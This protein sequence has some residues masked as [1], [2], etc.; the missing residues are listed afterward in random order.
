MADAAR[1]DEQTARG[2]TLGPLHGLPVAHK[3]LVDT[4]GIRTTRGSPFY[5]DN[6]PDARR[7]DRD[8]HARGRRDHVRQ[9]E[10]AGV[11]RRIADVQRPLR[12]DA[13]SVRP[14]ARPAAAAAA[15]RRWRWRAGWCRSPTAATPAA[16]CEIRRR[17]ATSSDSGRRRAACRPRSTAWS[18]LLGVRD[19][20]RASVADVAL[21]LS[22]IAGPRPAQS[23]RRSPKTARAFAAPL[24]RDFKGVRVAWWKGLGGIPFEPEIRASSTRTA[25]SS[26]AWAASIEEAEPDFTGVDEAFPALRFSAEPSAVLGAGAAAARVGEGHDQLRGRAKPNA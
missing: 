21:F 6:V 7:A 15:A 2:G 9:D 26:R 10:H 24:G 16:R 12:R 4:A 25:A 8:A 22:V 11:R 1:A 3:D 13:E 19:R 14:D 23:A 17:S 18:P 20:W 5:R